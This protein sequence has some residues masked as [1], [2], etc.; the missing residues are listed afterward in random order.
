MLELSYHDI[1]ADIW[2]LFPL[3]GHPSDKIVKPQ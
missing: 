3:I 2:L 1:V